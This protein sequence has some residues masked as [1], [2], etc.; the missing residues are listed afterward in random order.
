MKV[1]DSL[2]HEFNVLSNEDNYCVM[3]QTESFCV[4]F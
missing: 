3:D 4:E 2:S 1:S